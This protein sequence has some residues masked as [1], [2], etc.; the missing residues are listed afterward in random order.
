M[1]K[2]IIKRLPS[3][4]PNRTKKKKKKKHVHKNDKS[5]HSNY[6]ST[7]YRLNNVIVNLKIYKKTLISNLISIN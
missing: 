7:A 3:I 6:L 2:R 4:K 5:H 1:T